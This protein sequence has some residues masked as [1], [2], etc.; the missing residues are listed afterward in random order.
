MIADY[1]PR[2]QYSHS[3][4]AQNRLVRTYLGGMTV[5][6]VTA[7]GATASEHMLQRLYDE[8]VAPK[9]RLAARFPQAAHSRHTGGTPTCHWAQPLGG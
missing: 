4:P 1:R 6:G 7:P 3:F 8:A 2:V 5:D 9:P